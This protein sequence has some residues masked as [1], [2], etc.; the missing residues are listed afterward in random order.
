MLIAASCLLV[1]TCQIV[2]GTGSVSI[3]VP[4]IVIKVGQE[5]IALN[6][7]VN[8]SIIVQVKSVFTS[9]NGK[10][11]CLKLLLRRLMTRVKIEEHLKLKNLY[12]G[13]EGQLK[14]SKDIK[15]KWFMK[16]RLSMVF[17][18]NELLAV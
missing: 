5:V 16:L 18:L 6:T 14:A 3:L 1:T 17:R 4:V 11:I 10:I 12:E 13:C 2:Q 7:R 8:G 9:L 15:K